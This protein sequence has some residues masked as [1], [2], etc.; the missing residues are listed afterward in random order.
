MFRSIPEIGLRD[1]QLPKMHG[2]IS[3]FLS[4]SILWDSNRTYIHDNLHINY[5]LCH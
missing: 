2:V 1:I 5:V 4:E 3:E